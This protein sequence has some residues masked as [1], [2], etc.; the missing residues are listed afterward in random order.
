MVWQLIGRSQREI[1]VDDYAPQF[2]Q[3][4][5]ADSPGGESDLNQ[6][7]AEWLET[8]DNNDRAALNPDL[9]E[10]QRV[11]L[12]AAADA[13]RSCALALQEALKQ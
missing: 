3:K 6:F 7:V 12:N 11:N 5:F 1:E 9:F 4:P 8:A 2:P 13:L 10:S